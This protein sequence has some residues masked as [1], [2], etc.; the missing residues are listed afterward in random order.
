[1]LV[2][3]IKN[4]AEV[5]ELFGAVLFSRSF[6]LVKE[7]FHAIKTGLIKRLQNIQGG[8]QKSARTDRG[9]E[10]CGLF[11][12]VPEGAEQFRAFGVLNDILGKLA[13]VEVVSDEV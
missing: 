5:A 12:R 8:K 13:A 2:N 4:L 7:N 9:V 6:K 1:M 10:Q 11:Y 3:S